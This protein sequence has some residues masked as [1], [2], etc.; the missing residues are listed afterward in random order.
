MLLIDRFRYPVGPW[1]RSPGIMSTW[2]PGAT[3]QPANGCTVS[4]RIRSGLT[5]S[6]AYGL[7]DRGYKYFA[8][9]DLAGVGGFPDLGD[10]LVGL[11]RRDDDF[12][13]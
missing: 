2:L 1:T 11:R 5:G 6:H 8:V 7:L 10:H 4:N 3:D 13:F 12:D 9:A